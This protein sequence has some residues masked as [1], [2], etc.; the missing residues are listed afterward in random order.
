LVG[1]GGSK[2]IRHYSATLHLNP[3]YSR[4][5]NRRGNAKYIQ[6]DRANAEKDWRL[7]ATF[8]SPEFDDTMT[9]AE[10]KIITSKI[11]VIEAN[12]EK[13]CAC[14]RACVRVRVRACV[15]AVCLADAICE[16]AF[17]RC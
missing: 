16:C 9:V 6:G 3:Q 8:A 5:Y 12:Y 13:V 7:A 14:V 4:A 15:R 10:A 11:L 2:A 17:T 1:G